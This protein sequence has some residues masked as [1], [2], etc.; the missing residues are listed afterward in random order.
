MIRKA[1]NK[2]YPG[3]IFEIEGTKFVTLEN[4]LPVPVYYGTLIDIWSKVEVP[5]YCVMKKGFE[6]IWEFID[7]KKRGKKNDKTSLQQRRK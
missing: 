5:K 4:F 7:E 2:I 3:R 6:V 1:F